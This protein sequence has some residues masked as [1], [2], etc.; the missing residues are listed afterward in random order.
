MPHRSQILIRNLAY[1]LFLGIALVPALLYLFFGYSSA[2]QMVVD[3]AR[4]QSQHAN[5]VIAAHP[6]I[7]RHKTGMLIDPIAEIRHDNTYSLLT[8]IKGEVLAQTGESCKVCVSGQAPL[9]EFGNEAGTI[10]VDADLA[11]VLGQTALIG[12]IGFALG[13]LLIVIFNRY[14]L[15]PLQRRWNS[16]LQNEIALRESEASLKKA[17]TISGIGSLV[18]DIKTGMW[19]NSD[20]LDQLFGI[21]EAYGRTLEGWKALIHPDDRTHIV[22]YFT[23]DVLVQ[24][25]PFDKEYRIIRHNDQAERWVHGICKLEFDAQGQPLKMLCTIQDITARKQA[26]DALV[27][28]SLAIEQSPESIVITDLEGNIEYVNNTFTSV[29]GYS[30]NEVLGKNPRILQSGKTP[31]VTYAVM[32]ALLSRGKQWSGELINRNKDGRE[33]LESVVISPVRQADGRITNYVAVKTDITDKRQAEERIERLAHFDQLTD[34]PNRILL[35]DR[36]KFSLSLAQR[37]DEPVAVMFLDLDHFK[38][39]NDTLGHSIGDQLLMEIA[40]RLK[41]SLREQDTVSRLGG[42]EFILILPDTDADSAAHV[43]IKLIEAVSR[44]F[45]IRNHELITTPSIGI[46]IYPNDGEDLE[47]LSKNADAAMYRVKQGS[48]NDFCFFTQEMQEHSMRRLQLSNALRHA[49]AHHE[50]QLHYQPQVSIEDGHIV[51]A[52]ALLRWQHPELGMISP[53]E[54]IPIA[55]D[56]GLIIKI[57]EW[58]LRT[59]AVQ[60]KSWMDSGLPPMLMA[61]N[62]SAVQFRQANITEVITGILDEVGLPHEYLELELTEAAAMDDPKAAIAVMDKLLEQGIRMSI[63]DFGTGYSSLSYLKKFS[64]YKLKIDQSFVQN[65]TDDPDDK[66]IVTAI[67]SM[68]SS[69]GMHTIAEGVET[70]GQLDYL[71]LQGC[72]DAQGY[73]FSKPLTAEKF[74]SFA[75]NYR[76][77]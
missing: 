18:M 43:A 4:V 34:L 36:F 2:K 71:R 25:K 13:S 59:A 53:A 17:L 24:G 42:D 52:E 70:A 48:R 16:S 39:I 1:M 14:L 50:L 45:Q 69:L 10:R 62:L 3:D 26:E 73:Y 27:K 75:K 67:I 40:K 8:D 55:E 47:T 49:L 22:D 61:V 6:K 64:V 7:W 5:E 76:G 56:S 31:Q 35:N 23:K 58:V 65:I 38:N 46:A 9:M 44:P 28:L 63:D 72:N 29:T 11:P 77:K 57:G 33:Y 32:W 54:F 21:D 66:A 41:S 60:L 20:I 15:V 19:N 51:G 37:N 12:V 74:A 68:A 30:L